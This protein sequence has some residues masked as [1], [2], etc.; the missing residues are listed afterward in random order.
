MW[1]PLHASEWESCLSVLVACAWCLGE[2]KTHIPDSCAMMCP[3]ERLC[4]S[5]DFK[6]QMCHHYVT[7]PGTRRNVTELFDERTG[8]KLFGLGHA[9]SLARHSPAALLAA[10][11]VWL[12]ALRGWKSYR[13]DVCERAHVPRVGVDSSAG[14][15]VEAT[16][17]CGG[18]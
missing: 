7:S 11:P 9:Q 4:P 6:V 3:W 1:K 14:W 18:N 5:P 13:E 2:H 16:A 10:L 17:V 12:C 15:E 8:A